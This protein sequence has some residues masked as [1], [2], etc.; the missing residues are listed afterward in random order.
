MPALYVYGIVDAAEPAG[1]AELP[2]V[3]GAPA[4]DIRTVTEPGL[5]MTAVV[6]PAPAELRGKRRDLLAH[7]RVLE[8]LVEQGTVLPMRF[9]V[10]APDEP[11]LL[12]GL[13]S[14]TER[15]RA[16][17]H[18]LA[19]QVELNLKAVPDEQQ[20]VASAANEPAVRSALAAARRDGSRE[21][22][23]QLG[24]AVAEAVARRRQLC[25]TQLLNEL[26]PLASRTTTLGSGEQYALNAAFLL[27]RSALAEFTEAVDRLR[28][29]L[30]PAVDLTL[31][32]PLPP[33]SF[34]GN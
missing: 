13:R 11:T 7:Q 10:V 21:R 29:Q 3:G 30:S 32:G 17:L 6:S 14:E 12:A 15:Y 19:G 8:T 23:V 2:A 9:G 27:P 26:R 16:L 25:G 34:V 33:Y 1:L 28:G 31:T 24:Q 18:E 4:G 5:P 20:F 22:Q